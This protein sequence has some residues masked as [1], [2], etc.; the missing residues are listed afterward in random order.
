MLDP[1][2]VR[3]LAEAKGLRE[4]TDLA[5]AAGIS[6]PAVSQ[7]YGYKYV[8]SRFADAK[9][10]AALGCDAFELESSQAEL[11]ANRAVHQAWID[12]G[13]P[14]NVVLP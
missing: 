10:A 1:W 13:R 11:D 2:K 12:A 9:I 8:P 7:F 6:S 4:A 3:Q 5:K 14:S